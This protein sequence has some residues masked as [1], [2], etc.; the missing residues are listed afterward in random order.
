MTPVK[1][2]FSRTG[3]LRGMVAGAWGVISGVAPHVLHHAG[4]LAGAA[5]LAGTGGRVLFFFIGLAAAVPLL[6][7]L[8]RRFNTWVAPAMAIGVFAATYTL[9]SLFLGPLLT[10]GTGG[11]ATP[12]GVTTTTDPH[13]H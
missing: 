11:A 2:G 9:S 1:P 10:G 5:L 13:G 6:I 3:G 4:P 7:R 8:Y 12:P